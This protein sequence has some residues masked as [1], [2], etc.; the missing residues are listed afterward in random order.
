MITERRD[1]VP[2]P[3]GRPAC[4]AR[5]ASAFAAARSGSAQ[6]TIATPSRAKKPVQVD[7]RGRAAAGNPDPQFRRLHGARA[8]PHPDASA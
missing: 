2:P 7:P 4:V 1:G 8:R 3:R 6:P 5:S